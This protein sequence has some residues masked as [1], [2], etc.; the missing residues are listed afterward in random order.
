MEIVLKYILNYLPRSEKIRSG[1]PGYVFICSVHPYFQ[2]IPNVYLPETEYQGRLYITHI[3]RYLQPS[4]FTNLIIYE[5]FWPILV[6]ET[7]SN[8]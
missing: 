5:G 6:G 4:V 1:S 7:C 2:I 3:P 8:N